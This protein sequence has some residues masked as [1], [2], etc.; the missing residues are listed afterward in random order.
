M[1]PAMTV[2]DVLVRRC[3]YAGPLR[4][5]LEPDLRVLAVWYGDGESEDDSNDVALR[6][7]LPDTGEEP[8]KIVREALAG[9]PHPYLSVE[10][11]SA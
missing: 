3:P 5:W 8:E 1:L 9:F 7:Q 2:V 10:V 6:V 11:R 4:E